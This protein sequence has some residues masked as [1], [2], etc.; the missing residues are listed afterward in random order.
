MIRQLFLRSKF[1]LGSLLVKCDQ[2]TRIVFAQLLPL[3]YAIV[4]GAKCAPK[5]IARLM[6]E[7]KPLRSA[8]WFETCSARLL[9]PLNYAI[10]PG[11][12]CAPKTI[13]RLM[14]TSNP[15]RS[16]L[17]YNKVKNWM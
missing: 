4:P 13:A 2:P 16:A 6:L 14:L 1:L 11:A 8:L 9:L 15:A 5:T 17:W 12:K 7:V 3:N 10:V